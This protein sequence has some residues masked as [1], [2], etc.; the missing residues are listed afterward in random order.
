MLEGHRAL[1][2]PGKHLICYALLCLCHISEFKSTLACVA[3]ERRIFQNI[4][5]PCSFI[6]NNTSV[7]PDKAVTKTNTHTNETSV[8]VVCSRRVPVSGL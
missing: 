7:C 4:A 1:F 2:E 8:Q 5:F 6:K 3:K